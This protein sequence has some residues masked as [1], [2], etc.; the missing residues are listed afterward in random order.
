AEN[1]HLEPDF[2]RNLLLELSEKEKNKLNLAIS[3]SSK[4]DDKIK[5][6]WHTLYQFENGTLYAKAIVAA[7]Q[8]YDF[9]SL[10][11]ELVDLF[12][13]EGNNLLNQIHGGIFEI[14]DMDETS[15]RQ[16]NTFYIFNVKPVI[17]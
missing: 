17:W 13:A 3:I 9:K 16:G 12:I 2:Y 5:T 11:E 6:F 1:V 14:V 8:F 4:T 15:H 7:S 10:K